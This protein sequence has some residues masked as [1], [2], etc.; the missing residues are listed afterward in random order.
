MARKDDYGLPDETLQLIS[1]APDLFAGGKYLQHR[2]NLSSR[3]D[4]SEWIAA[5]RA[6][7][8]NNP[9]FTQYANRSNPE[10]ASA[11]TERRNLFAPAKLT[12]PRVS[13]EITLPTAEPL[14]PTRR[15]PQ[16]MGPLFIEPDPTDSDPTDPDWPGDYVEDTPDTGDKGVAAVDTYTPDVSVGTVITDGGSNVSVVGGTGNDTITGGTG[17]GG[18][19]GGGTGG[20]DGGGGGG[21]GTG[22]LNGTGTTGGTGTI[23]TTPGTGGTGNLRDAIAA[24]IDGT[25]SIDGTTSGLTS[26]AGA[27]AV[28]SSL[29]A[30]QIAAL[31]RPK[32][33]SV[34]LESSGPALDQDTGAT[35]VTFDYPELLSPEELKAYEAW[36]ATQGGGAPGAGKPAIEETL[37]NLEF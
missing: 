6:S 27:N 34:T 14:T 30:D 23:S 9:G 37:G 11:R 7:G 4:P 19:G 36:L 13:R 18:T 31:T 22:G 24:A 35:T 3:Q 8:T 16:V 28:G 5:L 32:V 10:S 25:A 15:T 2:L 17:G 29:T 33:P 1:A 12:I 21:S 20:G 26:G